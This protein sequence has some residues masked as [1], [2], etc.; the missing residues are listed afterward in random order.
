MQPPPTNAN[1][2]PKKR[3]KN[4]NL[5]KIWPPLVDTHANDSCKWKCLKILCAKNIIV[6]NNWPNVYYL[7]SVST[8]TKKK[9]QQI[10]VE[11]AFQTRKMNAKILNTNKK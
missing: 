11:N 4:L 6:N 9:K 7:Y 3:K 1:T 5:Q 10:W 8:Q 2:N